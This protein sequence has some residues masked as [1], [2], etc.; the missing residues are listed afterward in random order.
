[1]LA[2]FGQRARSKGR[3]L[4]GRRK[5]IL[6]ELFCATLSIFSFLNF[7]IFYFY[8]L[9]LFFSL[10]LTTEFRQF[11][12]ERYHQFFG[13]KVSASVSVRKIFL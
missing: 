1:M 9:F 3:D 5:I 11:F 8:F 13:E 12:G 10:F 4:Y 6:G 2:S 7:S